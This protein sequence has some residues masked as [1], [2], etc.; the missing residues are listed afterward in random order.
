MDDA[1]IN[2]GVNFVLNIVKMQTN[3][4]SSWD[5]SDYDVN[6]LIE[7]RTELVKIREK[8]SNFVEDAR[9]VLAEEQTLVVSQFNDTYLSL[10]G[11]ISDRIEYLL[12]K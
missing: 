8:M 4:M 6:E 5:I 10:V 9:E 11:R 1:T 3:E 7:L 2:M 12:L